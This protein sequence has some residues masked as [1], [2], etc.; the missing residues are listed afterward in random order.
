MRHND[1]TLS[2]LSLSLS[3][4]MSN[5]C[6]LGELLIWI[7]YHQLLDMN[8][9]RLNQST[10][11]LFH[12]KSKCIRVFV[13]S[14]LAFASIATSTAV[15]G[16][17]QYNYAVNSD[18]NSHFNSH[19]GICT[20]VSS[21]FIFLDG[22]RLYSDGYWQSSVCEYLIGRACFLSLHLSSKM[23]KNTSKY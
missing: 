12:L 13:L 19:F 10:R 14:L 4:I 11:E 3:L 15:L 2:F 7:N 22:C 17:S 6:S 20:L 5:K 8:I 9:K 1:D 16:I 23:Y 21:V 18:F